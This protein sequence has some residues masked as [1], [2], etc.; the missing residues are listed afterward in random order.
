MAENKCLQRFLLT[1]FLAFSIPAM[2]LSSCSSSEPNGPEFAV[3]VEVLVDPE[4]DPLPRDAEIWIKDQGSWPWRFASR[5]FKN[6]RT[7]PPGQSAYL[8]IS[9]DGPEGKEIVVPITM[10]AD[11]CPQGCWR[12]QI[13][14]SISDDSVKVVGNPIRNRGVTFSR[15]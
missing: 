12:D 7:H 3:R 6:L 4:S 9:P 10:T 5:D 14:I 1:L 13:V 15:R 2:F 8:Y 11:M